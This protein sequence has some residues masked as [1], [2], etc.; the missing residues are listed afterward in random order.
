MTARNLGGAMACATLALGLLLPVIAEGQ[1]SALV[2]IPNTTGTV[3]AEGRALTTVED[4]TRRALDRL[5]EALQARG[6][7]FAHVVVSNVF[8]KDTRDFQAM[9]AIYRTVFAVDPPTRA[10]VR[11]DLPDPDARIQI[12]VVAARGPKRVVT[13]QGLR[14]PELPYSWGIQVGRTLFVAGATSRSPDTYRPVRGDVETQTRR[15]F[16]NIGMVLEEARMGYGDLVS[17]RVF[18]DDPRAFEEMN[19]AYAGFVPADDP[20]ARATVR[21]GLMNVLFSTEIQCVAEASVDRR[22][23]IR[24]GGQRGPRPF[25]PALSTGNRLYLSGMVGSGPQGVPLEVD[26]QTRNALENLRATLEAGGMD[27]SHVVDAWVYLADIRD[28]GIVQEVLHEVL[29]QG[30]PS[31]TVVGTPL[32]G[33]QLRVEIQMVAER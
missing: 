15:I 2:Y 10:T 26:L 11:A 13:P 22:V 9:N 33:S 12:S 3:D 16:G 20:P 1:D 32:M 21:S 5:G 30:A 24:E 7:D 14:S 18:L 8:L 6:L 31:P 27:F 19:R 4:Q 17:C 28:W 25:S 23:V 29:P